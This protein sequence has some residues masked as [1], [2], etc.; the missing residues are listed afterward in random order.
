MWADRGAHTEFPAFGLDEGGNSGAG[1]WE[2]IVGRNRFN[3][4]RCAARVVAVKT[5]STLYIELSL[6]P[7]AENQTRFWA[8]QELSGR[9]GIEL[10]EVDHRSAR[11]FGGDVRGRQAS[12]VIYRLVAA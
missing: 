11:Q 12:D 4:L 9:A 6:E 1:R 8:G 10:R 7:R 2:R 3:P 5:E